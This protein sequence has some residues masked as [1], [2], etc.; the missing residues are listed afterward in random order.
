MFAARVAAGQSFPDL[1]RECR[2]VCGLCLLRDRAAAPQLSEG[3]ARI[4]GAPF[5]TELV[6]AAVQ[7]DPPVPRV[8]ARNVL[9]KIGELAVE[10]DF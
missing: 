3:Q 1:R 4:D 10:R 9:D 2:R 8:V 6:D 7:Q 5:V